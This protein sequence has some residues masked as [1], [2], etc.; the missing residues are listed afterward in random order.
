MSSPTFEPRPDEPQ[1][2]A[3]SGYTGFDADADTPGRAEQAADSLKGPAGDVKD[4]AV[5][6][7]RDVLDTAKAEAAQV[8]DEAKHQGRRLLDESVGELRSQAGTL[9]A[10]LADTVD[11]FAEEL[12][13]LSANTESD[14]PLTHFAGDAHDWGRKAST[15]LRDNEPD[16]VLTSVRRY[17]A[18]NPWTF[19]AI[20][21]GAGLIAGRVARSLRD[22]NADDAPQLPRD[23]YGYDEARPA[24]GRD[25]YA[26]NAPREE[27][28]GD[29]YGQPTTP[30]L[31][32]PVPPVPGQPPVPGPGA[33]P[34]PNPWQGNV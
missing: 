31:A 28:F 29:D 9:Q 4:T 8:A 16:Q 33:Q 24:V 1:V 10:K 26:L 15:W 25:P 18:R 19:L 2:P 14:G 3:D 21:A 22:A 11:A 30:G 23:T 20:A 7:G 13:V 34:N 27:H 6:A 12:G 5:D 17:A 32:N